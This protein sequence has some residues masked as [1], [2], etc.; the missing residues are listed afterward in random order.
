MAGRNFTGGDKVAKNRSAM[1]RAELSK[2][3][4]VRNTSQR[5]AMKTAIKKFEEAAASGDKTTLD[6]TFNNATRLVDKA[7]AKGILHP[8]ARDRKKSQL[9]K[10]LQPKVDASTT[11]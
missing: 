6:T 7:A 2:E 9:A 5:S 1:K 4:A 10:K 3:R 11:A 8:N